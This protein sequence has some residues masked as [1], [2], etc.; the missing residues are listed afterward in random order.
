[1]MITTELNNNSQSQ[2]GQ[3]N[4]AHTTDN[5]WVVQI[6]EA[7]HLRLSESKQLEP[8]GRAKLGKWTKILMWAMR[9][10]VI[11]SFILIIAQIY[12]SLKAH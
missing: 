5:A 9:F 6:L 10:Y 1:M 2:V 11:L 7:D 3:A 8:F 12:I 4:T